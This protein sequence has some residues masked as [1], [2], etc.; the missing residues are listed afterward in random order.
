[1]A[2]FQQTSYQP[3]VVIQQPVSTVT[4]VVTQQPAAMGGWSSGLCD[5]FQDPKSCKFFLILSNEERLLGWL[6]RKK[7]QS[8]PGQG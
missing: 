6:L 8:D 3:Q 5:C 4:T 1:M 7:F 2:Q